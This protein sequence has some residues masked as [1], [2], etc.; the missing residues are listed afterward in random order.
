MGQTTKFGYFTQNNLVI[1]PSLRV[2]DVVKE[3]AEYIEMGKEELSA[4][5]FL[6]HF[7]FNHGLQHSYYESLS[8]GE[9]R[10][11]Q[12]LI[13][14]IKNPNFLILDEPTNDLDIYTLEKLEEFLADFKGCLIIVSHD[15]YFL[16]KLSDHLFVFQGNGKIKDFVG[17][18]SD[19]RELEIIRENLKKKEI[20][21]EKKTTEPI[22][23][24]KKR[25]ASYKEKKEFESLE[26]EIESLETEK[27]E[28]LEK[29]NSGKLSPEDFQVASSRYGKIEK[30]L[31]EKEM[32]WL[33][34]S[35]LMYTASQ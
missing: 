29:M 17:S 15:R 18:Y 11:L 21:K 23:K 30:E 5:V 19:Y 1:D 25:K 26:M 27:S 13:T 22:V 35:E 6:N 31:E 7:G 4:S 14:L 28:L 32:R 16:D 12:L 2:L 34:L 24:Q 3:I 8:G 33:E 10:K 20:R 9:K